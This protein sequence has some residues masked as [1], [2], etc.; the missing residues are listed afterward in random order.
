MPFLSSAFQRLY[1]DAA[2]F[3]L[4]SAFNP[5]SFRR[6]LP[7]QYQEEGVDDDL[8]LQA[9]EAHLLEQNDGTRQAVVEQYLR[10]GLLEEPD[11][12]NVKVHI[13]FYDADFFE[14]MG[15]V[16]ANAGRFRCALRWYRELIGRLEQQTAN[17][18]S[19][20][21]SV[22]ASVGYC[23]YSLGLFAEAICWS[24]SCI[25][26]APIA[27]TVCRALINYEAQMSG[28]V[29]LIERSGPR[30]RYTA[31]TFDADRA[32]Q[33][34]PRLKAAMQAFA[35]FHDV[36]LDWVGHDSPLP[37]VAPG[38]YP[39]RAEFDAG[40]LA[41]HKMNLIFATCAQAGALVERGYRVEAKRL[42]AEAAI[43]EPAANMVLERLGEL[44]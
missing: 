5:I 7:F 42:L 38:G 18:C 35:P 15:L 6:V 19:D 31:S 34:T 39:F 33:N 22:Y 43:L 16:Y 20:T 32:I 28:A 3:D 24:K 26:P 12:Q 37:E 40:T 13:D 27:D 30:T 14:L 1:C 4:F 44:P 11:A 36:Y 10:C 23:L 2:V 9:E 8:L 25:G 21:E 41:R 17:C 29:R